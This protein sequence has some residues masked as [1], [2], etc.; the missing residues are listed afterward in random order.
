NSRTGL[1][2]DRSSFMH[3]RIFSSSVLDGHNDFKFGHGKTTW[4]RIVKTED[5][6]IFDGHL[7]TPGV[8]RQP[9][10]NAPSPPPAEK[11]YLLLQSTKAASGAILSE[12]IHNYTQSQRNPVTEAPTLS[13]SSGTGVLGG[14]EMASATE[15]LAGVSVQRRALS[16]L[17]SQ[18][19]GS[20][21]PGSSSLDLA[22]RPGFTL[23]QFMHENHSPMP[24]IPVQGMQHN[25]GLVTDKLLNISSQSSTGVVVSNGYLASGASSLDKVHQ[26]ESLVPN[27]G[28]IRNFESPM[29]GLLQGQEM[30]SSQDSRSKDVRP[31]IDLM[32]RSSQMSNES[33]EQ[34]GIL[35]HGNR[36]FM[37]FPLTRCY[38]PSVFDSQHM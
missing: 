1:L 18:S 2:M 23:E 3:P 22:T 9:Y 5:Q 10:S 17:S 37:E 35:Q 6:L 21:A 32:Q 4:P 38:E 14:L 34:S 27:M 8:N 11:L 31:T 13:S 15:S 19:W 20:R 28:G 29:H 30:R 12:G 16:L 33:R 36:Q 7:Q 25:F 24:E 26:G